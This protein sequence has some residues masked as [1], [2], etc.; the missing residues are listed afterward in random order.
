[1]LRPPDERDPLVEKITNFG[2]SLPQ[3]GLSKMNTLLGLSRRPD[4]PEASSEKVTV[5]VRIRP[6]SASVSLHEKLG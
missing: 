2:G 1:M 4:S 3:T 6:L 5:A